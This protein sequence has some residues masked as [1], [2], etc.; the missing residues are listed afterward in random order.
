MKREGEIGIY[1]SQWWVFFLFPNSL[2]G[3][4]EGGGPTPKP[5]SGL[6]VNRR[7]PELDHL[8][9]TGRRA[10]H[11]AVEQV[12]A[13]EHLDLGYWPYTWIEKSRRKPSVG[14]FPR[15]R[16]AQALLMR[17]RSTPSLVASIACP[18]GR[19]RRTRGS[20][21]HGRTCQ[22]HEYEQHEGPHILIM[23]P[24]DGPKS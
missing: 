15:L 6:P 16:D 8:V 21:A 17:D 7:R 2:R 5:A 13:L 20:C 24:E 18:I 23:T 12:D 1:L 19:W 22:A 11:T 10:G 14:A 4:Q 3:F 9:M